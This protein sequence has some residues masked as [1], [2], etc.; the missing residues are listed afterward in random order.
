MS[1]VCKF[2]MLY[3]KRQVL[4][5]QVSQSIWCPFGKT[6]KQEKCLKE[7]RDLEMQSALTG[8]LSA[9]AVLPDCATQLNVI[10]TEV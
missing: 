9:H 10:E 4:T 6:G 7:K 3:L 1:E 2:K 8:W 5:D